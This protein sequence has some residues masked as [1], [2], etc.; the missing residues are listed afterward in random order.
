M[1]APTISIIVPTLNEALYIKR[2]LISL[3]SQEIDY[4]YEIIISD[5]CSEDNT[6]EIAREYADKIVVEPKRTIAAGRNKGASVAEGK[7]LVFCTA[8]TYYPRKWLKLVTSPIIKEGYGVVFGPLYP[9]DGS[10]I[11]D[12]FS[13]LFLLPY[14]YFASLLRFYY[15]G[16]ENIAIRKDVF[17]NLSGFNSDLVTSE[18]TD[19]IK[20]ASNI[21]KVKFE[22]K[23]GVYVSMRR[24]HKW[25]YVNYIKFH[26]RNY[27][28][29]HF[30]KRTYS[31][32]EPVR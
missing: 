29:Y 13:R 19:L 30:F 9:L 26:T 15:V 27:I 2:T 21:A 7:I 1:K 12:V 10:L 14:S 23:A 4:D 16:G 18:D 5:G 22:L 3:R 25:G 8:D 6:I 20:R 11:E 17:K 32:Y 24:V 28:N 31:K